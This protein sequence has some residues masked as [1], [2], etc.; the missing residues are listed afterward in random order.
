MQARELA[1]R[2]AEKKAECGEC[3]CEEMCMST[4]EPPPPPPPAPEPSAPSDAGEPAPAGTDQDNPLRESRSRTLACQNFEQL[5]ESFTGKTLEEL[6][7]LRPRDPRAENPDIERL[8]NA[9]LCEMGPRLASPSQCSLIVCGAAGV[10]SDVQARC[11]GA[12]RP[13]SLNA[14]VQQCMRERRCREDDTD[15]CA[16]VAM[17]IDPEIREPRPFP[18]PLGRWP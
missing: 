17:P 16:D 6:S 10:A 18:T 7:P 3:T 4:S 12:P 2:A 5:F 13:V 1:A 14:L 9:V 8:D 15:C 11:C